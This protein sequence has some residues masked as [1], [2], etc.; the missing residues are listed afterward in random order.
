MK[1][2]YVPCV[3]FFV[4]DGV[5][6]MPGPPADY[7][8][9]ARS[10]M[11]RI[12]AMPAD[13]RAL[14]HEYGLTIVDA[15]LSCGVKKARHIRHLVECVRE[16]GRYGNSRPKKNF[17]D[18]VAKSEQENG[19]LTILDASRHTDSSAS[20]IAPT[21]VHATAQKDDGRDLKGRRG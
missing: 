21:S 11:K 12:D 6:T 19:S 20:I 8:D 13:I 10:R 15:F 9:R 14:V 18:G 4:G 5:P 3:E 16:E 7:L 17:S 2:A 1:G